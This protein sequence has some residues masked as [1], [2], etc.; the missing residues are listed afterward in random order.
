M[1]LHTSYMPWSPALGSQKLDCIACGVRGKEPGGKGL[2]RSSR[3]TLRPASRRRYA[4]TEPPNPDPTMTAWKCSMLSPCTITASGR[5]L[6]IASTASGASVWFFGEKTSM[7]GGIMRMRPVA[8]LNSW[9]ERLRDWA[10]AYRELVLA[11]QP[12]G[13]GEAV[14]PVVAVSAPPRA[15]SPTGAPEGLPVKAAQDEKR[16]RIGG[17]KVLDTLPGPH[18]ILQRLLVA[19]GILVLQFG[20]RPALQ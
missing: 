16:L 3:Q 10:L 4:I 12:D 9:Q 20:D 7:D 8:A 13:A 6:R 1:K 19:V 11:H 18:Q 14:R 15:V 17:R 2:P 5:S